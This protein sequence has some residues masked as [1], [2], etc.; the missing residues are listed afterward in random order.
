MGQLIKIRK[1][2]KLR[3]H[4]FNKRFTQILLKTLRM[5]KKV[6]YYKTYKALTTKFYYLRL[7]PVTNYCVL[8]GNSRGVVSRYRVVRHEFKR[9]ANLGLIFG[10]RK[11]SF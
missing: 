10:V 8:T 6:F 1:D 7:K 9:L 2:F 11:A 3:Y 5:N 4:N